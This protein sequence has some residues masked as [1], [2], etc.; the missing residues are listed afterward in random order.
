VPGAHAIR[1]DFATPS[2][3]IALTGSDANGATI[4]QGNATG[5]A[6]FAAP[7]GGMWLAGSVALPSGVALRKLRIQPAAATDPLAIDNV[8][9]TMTDLASA[10]VPIPPAAIWASALLLSA[11]GARRSRRSASGADRDAS[12][13]RDADAHSSAPASGHAL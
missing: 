12:S 3:Q 5:S 13:L 4:W 10:D 6:P 7:G 1:F 8:G 2:G 11:L 9:F